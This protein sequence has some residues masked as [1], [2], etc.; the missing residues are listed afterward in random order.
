MNTSVNFS[1]QG[2]AQ[3]GQDYEPL[4][5]AALLQA[6]QTQVTVTLQSIQKDVNFEP[7]DMIV[8]H[9]PTRVG[10]VFVKDGA[11]VTPGEAI[12]SLTEPDLTRHPPGLGR[13]PDACSRLGRPAPSRSPDASNQVPG[14]ITELD[15]PRRH[16][17]RHSGESSQVY[18]GKIEVSDLT[19]ADGSPVSITV[20]DQ[21]VNNVLDRPDRRGKT[22]RC[23]GTKSCA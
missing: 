14:T 3:P 17:F 21:Q 23:R 19:G 5:G 1:V 8:G 16:R 2:T 9:W 10:Q 18:E 12:L 6:G 22:E 13:R 11:T 4:V 20:V 7:T 15:R